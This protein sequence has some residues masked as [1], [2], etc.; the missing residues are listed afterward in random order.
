MSANTTAAVSSSALSFSATISTTSPIQ[1]LTLSNTGTT[2]LVVYA[3]AISLAGT[4]PGQFALATTSTCLNAA[5][6]TVAA[7]ASCTVDVQYKPTAAAVAGTTYT[8]SVVFNVNTAVKPS[9]NLTGIAIAAPQVYYIHSDH[10]DSPRSITNTAGQE[11]WRWDNT[12]PFGNNIANENP[13][14]LGTFTFNLRFPGQYFDRETGLHYNVNRDYNPA[15]GRYIE[16]DPIGLQ[17]GINTFGYV[18]GNPLGFVDPDGLKV[19][20]GGDSAK[21][22]ELKKAYKKV[23]KTKRGRQLC[24]ILEKSEVTYTITGDT[25]NDAF[26][27]PNTNTINV[28]PNFHPPT[29]T[30]DGTQP[31]STDVILGHEIGHAATGTR[32][33]GPG[34][35]DN[36]NKNEN[37][38]R[39]GLGYPARTRY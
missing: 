29:S 38:I 14:K 12:D 25:S 39:K 8:A 13:A 11:V 36:V 16:S 2:S 20:Y 15:V 22:Q 7:G 37:P 18:G 6:V 30:T 5:G 19:Q 4:N 33:V 17:G 24:E 31:A 32:D 9:A 23:R 3:G 28:D 26:Y 21:N 27:N 1:K 35:I 34:N 10:L